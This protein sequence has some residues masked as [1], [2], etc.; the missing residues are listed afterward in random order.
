MTG[1]PSRVGG[2]HGRVDGDAGRA[3][4][5]LHL[6]HRGEELVGNRRGSRQE[7]PEVF[8]VAEFQSSM[9]DY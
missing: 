3:T 8:E 1:A 2:A 5:A 9:L 6:T 4:L 7:D